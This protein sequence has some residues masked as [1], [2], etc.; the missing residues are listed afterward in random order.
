[1]G[2][3]LNGSEQSP[4]LMYCFRY[5]LSSMILLRRLIY[6]RTENIVLKLEPTR[7]HM[8]LVAELQLHFQVN[9][10]HTLSQ[11]KKIRAV[12]RES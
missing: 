12:L 1:M 6:K 4:F 8:S 5:W 10:S 2:W 9:T 7:E 3:R 11:F